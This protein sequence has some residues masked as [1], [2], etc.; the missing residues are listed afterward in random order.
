MNPLVSIIVTT[1]NQEKTIGRTLDSI[2]CQECQFDFEIVIGEDGSTDSTRQVCE[3]YVLRNPTI[4][5]LMPQA[6]NKGIVDNYFDCLLA[7]QENIVLLS[8]DRA[9]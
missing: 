6:P 4:V 1:Y 5:K 7:T 9:R 3:Q 2:L 8:A